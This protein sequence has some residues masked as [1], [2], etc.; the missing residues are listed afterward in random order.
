MYVQSLSSIYTMYEVGSVAVVTGSHISNVVVV[1][2]TTRQGARVYRA[3]PFNSHAP[4]MD[5]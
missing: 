2:V 1:C 3:I 4:P 5:D